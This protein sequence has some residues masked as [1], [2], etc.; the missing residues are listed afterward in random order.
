MRV[1]RHCI[2]AARGELVLLVLHERDEWTDNKGQAFHHQRRQLIDEG[3]AA[4]GGHDN[5]RIMAFENC[6]DRLPLSFLKLTMAEALDEDL[7]SVSPRCLGHENIL[8]RNCSAYRK[9]G[10]TVPCSHSLAS[11]TTSFPQSAVRLVT[12]RAVLSSS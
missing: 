5:Q 11:S 9:E 8:G 10:S 7:A 1:H 12:S 6:L 4:A 3:F 2:D